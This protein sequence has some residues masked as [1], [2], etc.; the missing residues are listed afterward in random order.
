MKLR[1]YLLD[2]NIQWEVVRTET[3]MMDTLNLEELDYK[4]MDIDSFAVYEYI[5]ENLRDG[6]IVY[7][8]KY[9][10]GELTVDKVIIAE[11]ENPLILYKRTCVIKLKD[12]VYN[13]RLTPEY[14]LDMYRFIVI[15]NWMIANGYFI[16]NENRE[17]KYM[18]I[19]TSISEIEDEEEAEAKINKLEQYLNLMDKLASDNNI[20]I[21][22]D[23]A[24][25]NI[26]KAE[27][28]DEVTYI[29]NSYMAQFN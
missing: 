3:A 21:S 5:N 17:E 22:M 10:E 12:Y 24:V 29:F 28:S 27:T 23:E 18:E 2:R 26:I 13:L 4:L 25:D 11:D 6:K 20:I 19:I 1:L 14:I 7:I 16:T 15:N 9:L 8:P